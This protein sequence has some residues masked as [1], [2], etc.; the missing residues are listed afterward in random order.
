MY[1]CI[2]VYVCIYIRTYNI[3][4]GF[5][6]VCSVLVLVMGSAERAAPLARQLA[7]SYLRE[8]MSETI[9]GAQQVVV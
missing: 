2:Y 3:S 6:D 7:S 5:H 1:I 8:V 9:V 4:Q